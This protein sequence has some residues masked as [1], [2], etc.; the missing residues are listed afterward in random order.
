M[1]KEI[2]TRCEVSSHDSPDDCWI[3]IRNIVYDITEFLQEHQGGMEILIEYAGSDATE[4]F[5]SVGHSVKA[6][7]IMEKYAVGVLPEDQKSH[8]GVEYVSHAKKLLCPVH[9]VA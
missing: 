7:M 3:I 9:L 6:R 8:Y 2:I 4:A 5:E 1:L